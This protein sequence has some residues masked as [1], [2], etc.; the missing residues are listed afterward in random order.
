MPCEMFTRMIRINKQAQVNL[1]PLRCRSV[2]RKKFLHI[3]IHLL[4]VSLDEG[5]HINSRV[6]RVKH[7]PHIVMMCKVSKHIEHIVH[8]TFMW[9]SKVVGKN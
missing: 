9:H 1:L 5:T 4:P 3:P 2:T 8:A 6:S 7:D